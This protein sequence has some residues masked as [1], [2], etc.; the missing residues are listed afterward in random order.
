[1]SE[2]NF[3]IDFYDTLTQPNTYSLIL[4]HA[5]NYIMKHYICINNASFASLKYIQRFDKYEYL[6]KLN[7]EINI[8]KV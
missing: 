2:K 8:N 3:V 5:Q 6:L 7:I 1:M 4:A